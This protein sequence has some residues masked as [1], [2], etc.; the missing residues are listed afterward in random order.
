MRLDELV[1]SSI[2]ALLCLLIL[3]RCHRT[4]A[5]VTALCAQVN[6]FF[7]SNAPFTFGVYCIFSTVVSFFNVILG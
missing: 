1:S 6:L 7:F 5:F 3:K 4:V 2:A